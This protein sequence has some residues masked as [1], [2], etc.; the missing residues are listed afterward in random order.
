MPFETRNVTVQWQ[1]REGARAARR[2]KGL[3]RCEGPSLLRIPSFR[4][5]KSK[6][7]FPSWR[8]PESVKRRRTARGLLNAQSFEV[9][10]GPFDEVH[11]RPTACL[12][13]ARKT[14]RA[15]DENLLVALPRIL[16]V[17]G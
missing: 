13:E 10:E 15:W 17:F 3:V 2:P 7:A 1:A 6:R 11:H 14:K 4:G 9:I 8:H 12:C 16:S 5:R